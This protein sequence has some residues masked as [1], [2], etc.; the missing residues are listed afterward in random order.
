MSIT[1]KI[2]GT[3]NKGDG[4]IQIN[5]EYT[6]SNGSKVMNPYI[7]MYENFIGKT[8]QEITDWIDRQIN[9]QCDR[10]LEEEGL[11]NKTNLTIMNTALTALVDR[12]YVKD[13]VLHLLTNK[14][15]LV[16]PYLYERNYLPGEVVIKTIEINRDGQ[17]TET[18]I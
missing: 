10:Y 15:N 18:N 17:I 8:Q 9:F 1:A 7:V 2:K 4:N 13:T 6:M 3:T 14:N 16:T 11:R 5:V 12:T